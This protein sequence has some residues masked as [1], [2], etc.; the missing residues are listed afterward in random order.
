VSDAAK[1]A[2]DVVGATVG[3]VLLLPLLLVLALAIRVS[4]PGPTLF[5]QQRVGRDGREFVIWKL[6]TMVVHAEQLRAGLMPQSRESSWLF[7]DADPRVTPL[8]RVLRRTSLDELPQLVNVLR[9]DMSL[10]GPRPLPV[11]EHDA[12]PEW[13]AERVGVRPGIT[14]VWQVTGRTEIGFAEMLRLDCEYA[15]ERSLLVDV[16]ILIRTMRAVVGGR[17]AN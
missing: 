12:L 8:G 11:E 17:G 14:G 3:L 16:R 2:L 15:R 5:R 13:A 6:R 10:V 9:G 7:I 4:S 1:R